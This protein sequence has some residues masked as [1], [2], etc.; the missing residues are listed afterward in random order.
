[1]SDRKPITYQFIIEGLADG[2]EVLGAGNGAGLLAS[3][4]SLQFFCAKPGLLAAIKVGQ[5][6]SSW[7]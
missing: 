1:M 6:F 3:G 4:A 7:A 5:V 2:L